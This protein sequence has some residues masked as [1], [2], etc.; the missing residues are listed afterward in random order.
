MCMQRGC[1]IH[2]SLAEI[3]DSHVLNQFFLDVFTIAVIK[4]YMKKQNKQKPYRRKGYM[5]LTL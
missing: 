1:D 4:F 3:Y 2:D 5:R